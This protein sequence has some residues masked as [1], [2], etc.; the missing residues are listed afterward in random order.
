MTS[1]N[2]LYNNILKKIE[3]IKELSKKAGYELERVSSSEIF[4]YV[5]MKK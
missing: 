2:L 4:T 5:K 1:N 3:E